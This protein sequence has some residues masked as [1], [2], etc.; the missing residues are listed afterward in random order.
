MTEP[1]SVLG[2]AEDL[3][4][5]DAW[6]LTKQDCHKEGGKWNALDGPLS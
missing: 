1:P 3:E 4:T 6:V 5:S 2:R